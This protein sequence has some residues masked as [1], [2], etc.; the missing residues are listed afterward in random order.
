[1]EFDIAKERKLDRMDRDVTLAWMVNSIYVRTQNKKRLDALE[2]F[3]PK[4]QKPPTVMKI[5]SLAEQR[6]GLLAI[7]R[8]YG[9]P[10][11][12]VKAS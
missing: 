5:P 1:V 6:A 3:L 8:Q 2:A 9:I 7:S 12:E 4:R 11:V 10:I